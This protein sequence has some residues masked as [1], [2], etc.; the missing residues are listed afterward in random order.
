M[1]VVV[2]LCVALRVVG[3]LLCVVFVGASC[4]FLVWCSV[5]PGGRLMFAVCWSLFVVR[6]RLLFAV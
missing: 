1:F 2:C 6:Y 4:C 3:C 5:F